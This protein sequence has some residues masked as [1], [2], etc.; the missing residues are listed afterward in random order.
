MLAEIDKALDQYR[1]QAESEAERRHAHPRLSRGGGA[2]A[3][4]D[5]DAQKPDEQRDSNNAGLFEHLGIFIFGV[6]LGGQ[7]GRV[8]V[9]HWIDIFMRS[10]PGA[11]EW[12]LLEFSR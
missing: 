8:L 2:N 10:Q 5:H 12:E 9:V 6:R 3:G 1:R 7:I 4:R 11:D